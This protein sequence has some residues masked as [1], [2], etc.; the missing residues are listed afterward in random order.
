MKESYSARERVCGTTCGTIL[1]RRGGLRFSRVIDFR[2]VVATFAGYASSK[3]KIRKTK[4]ISEKNVTADHADDWALH[5]RL[6]FGVR[7]C[8]AA[9]P[10]RDA[11]TDSE[12]KITK[13]T[14]CRSGEPTNL[15]F[16][17]RR[18]LYTAGGLSLL[19][20]MISVSSA[21]LVAP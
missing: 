10:L 11:P 8:S 6:R 13:E 21:Q 17:P 3:Q 12:Q 16:F 4:T 14:K 19:L 1:T 2:L 9:F 15:H 20:S 7:Q 18:R 5:S